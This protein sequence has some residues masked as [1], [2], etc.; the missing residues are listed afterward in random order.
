MT[1]PQPYTPTPTDLI[2][3]RRA[4]A[5]AAEALEAGD[6]PFGSVLVGSSGAVLAEDRNRI[7]TLND[8]TRHP[9]FELARW[10]ATNLTPEERQEATMYT[11]GE[12]CVMCAAAHARVGLGPIVYVANN[13]QLVRWTE[14]FEREKGKGEE[15]VEVTMR[16]VTRV[17]PLPVNA[18]APFVEVRGPVGELEGDILELHRRYV[19]L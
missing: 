4:I 8:G 15:E 7:A 12:H 2:H 3:L 13:E 1:A 5:L 14:A 17:A 16:R 11:S 6:A 18:V 19:G 9:E 10:A